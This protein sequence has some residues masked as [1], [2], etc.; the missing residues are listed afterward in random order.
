[1]CKAGLRILA[2]G[3][4]PDNPCI[5]R[6]HWMVEDSAMGPPTVFYPI[7]REIHSRMNPHYKEDYRE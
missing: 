3:I 5:R 6:S 1:M 2:L 4:S 7:S